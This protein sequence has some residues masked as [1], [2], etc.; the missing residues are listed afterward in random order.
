[1]ARL[2]DREL[3]LKTIHQN[4]K[5]D[6]NQRAAQLLHYI[7]NAPIIDPVHAAGACYCKECK[8][9][10]PITD[11]VG[12]CIRESVMYLNVSEKSFCSYGE[13]TEE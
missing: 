13:R 1:M 10:S 11:I 12:D 8:Y 9:Y 3:L 5:I 4:P 7:L 6:G 2:I